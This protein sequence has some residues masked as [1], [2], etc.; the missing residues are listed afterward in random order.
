MFVQCDD[1]G[2]NGCPSFVGLVY[3]VAAHG[4]VV[5]GLFVVG[6]YT[7]F[8]SLQP[9]DEVEE[10]LLCGVACGLDGGVHDLH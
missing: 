2:G 4:V 10:V 7:E 5:D 3:E 6:V 1:V 9:A 8:D